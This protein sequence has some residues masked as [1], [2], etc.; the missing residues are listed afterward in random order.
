VGVGV[1][2]GPRGAT[3]GDRLGNGGGEGDNGQP[4]LTDD[5]WSDDSDTD[6]DPSGDGAG[7]SGDGP[8]DLIDDRSHDSDGEDEPS[9][10][11][12]GP[13][14]V[15]R[16]DVVPTGGTRADWAGDVDGGEDEA[17]ALQGAFR[18]AGVTALFP[19]DVG[20]GGGSMSDFDEPD[21]AWCAGSAPPT[22]G[23]T[24]YGG[25]ATTTRSAP[26]YDVRGFSPPARA[27]RDR[28]CWIMDSGPG[29]P[30][31]RLRPWRVC[32]NLGT[33]DVGGSTGPRLGQPFAIPPSWRDCNGML[34]PVFDRLMVAHAELVPSGS[35]SPFHLWLIDSGASNLNVVSSIPGCGVRTSDVRVSLRRLSGISGA[36]SGRECT[37][38]LL[39]GGVPL[40]VHVL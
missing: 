6:G 15:W 22:G 13:P 32:V 30:S 25:S 9:G 23:A 39:F 19:V 21:A 34:F 20:S 1:D 24:A 3:D 27:S 2:G 11:R 14:I 36:K 8:P 35:V 12:V 40:D 31:D 10:G 26:I 38:H 16:L 5:D 17:F 18:R 37:V 28:R 4:D 29:S 7:E 33:H